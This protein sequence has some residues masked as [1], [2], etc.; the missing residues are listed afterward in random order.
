MKVVRGNKKLDISKVLSQDIPYNIKF[1]N[2]D[3]GKI[4]YLEARR[5]DIL[6][7]M[8]ASVSAFPYVHEVFEI[9]GKRLID[10][11]IPDII[12][13]EHIRAKHP[14]SYIIVVLNGQTTGK[15]IPKL[16]N[17][18]EGI[19]MYW[20]FSDSKITNLF[21]SA[22]KRLSKDLK[23]IKNDPRVT[24]INLN[25]THSIKSRTT[26]KLQLQQTY[27]MGIEA[28]EKALNNLRSKS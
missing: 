4:E 21:K 17:Y 10:G 2:L 22:E 16:K 14:D 19:V 20:M 25:E 18:I 8:E 9:D 12:G 11:A 15:L 5:N 23:I 28:G 7:I 27:K 26:T 3:N 6:N 13:I 24:L 1:L